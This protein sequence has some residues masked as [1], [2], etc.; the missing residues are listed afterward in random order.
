MA[1]HRAFMNMV[2]DADRS[3]LT[4]LMGE[5]AGDDGRPGGALLRQVFVQQTSLICDK[6]DL[7][8]LFCFKPRCLK[9]LVL[10]PFA[11]CAVCH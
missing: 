8:A 1:Y 11:P 10:V 6:N 2:H 4:S 7:T 5:L 9:D 3:M